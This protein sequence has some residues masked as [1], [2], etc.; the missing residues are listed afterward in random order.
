MF[1][2]A[3]K[4]TLMYIQNAYKY[5]MSARASC[6]GSSPCGR[7]SIVAESW[8]RLCS[9]SWTNLRGVPVRARSCSSP[10][11]LASNVERTEPNEGSHSWNINCSLRKKRCEHA[12]VLP[13]EN[14]LNQG[15]SI[16]NDEQ[17]ERTGSYLDGLCL[18]RTKRQID[19]RNMN[20]Y[21]WGPTAILLAMVFVGEILAGI[22]YTIGRVKRNRLWEFPLQTLLTYALYLVYVYSVI[23]KLMWRCETNWVLVLY[24]T[25]TEGILFAGTVII[26]IIINIVCIRPGFWCPVEGVHPGAS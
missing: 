17:H 23:I 9:G 15:R 19:D 3:M 8:T 1:F 4:F 24:C 16:S 12:A 6:N 22:G 13:V 21:W 5:K 18:G 26:I 14:R 7:N 10:V 25:L 11:P 2:L 20:Y